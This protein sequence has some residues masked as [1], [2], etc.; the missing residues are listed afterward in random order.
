MFFQIWSEQVFPTRRDSATFRDKQTDAPLLS[1]GK[2]TT[3][4]AQNL[5][6]GRDCW[7]S[8]SKSRTGRGKG[9]YKILTAVPSHPEG[10]NE[11]E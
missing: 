1:R 2:G 6:K 5:A 8:L 11:T 4:Q 10:Q 7:N 3:G 9:K